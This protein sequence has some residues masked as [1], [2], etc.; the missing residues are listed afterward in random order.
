[1]R[2]ACL[3]GSQ[4]NR[5]RSVLVWMC[6]YD[7]LRV[8]EEVGVCNY[9]L[10]IPDSES[11]EP[12]EEVEVNGYKLQKARTVAASANKAGQCHTRLL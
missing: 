3:V 7:K 5:S 4:V 12:R 8:V 9:L 6:G 11:F 1:M 10:Q 2:L